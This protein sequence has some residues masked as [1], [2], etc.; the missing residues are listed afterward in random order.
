MIVIL[1]AVIECHRC[2]RSVLYG[3]IQEEQSI[4]RGDLDDVRDLA[5]EYGAS[6]EAISD[7]LRCEFRLKAA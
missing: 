4:I 5:K 1:R 3:R 2:G 6:E 7:A